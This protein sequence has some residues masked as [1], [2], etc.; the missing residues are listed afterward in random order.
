MSQHN[1]GRIGKVRMKATGFEFRVIP[2]ADDPESDIGASMI[3]HA[4][5]IA[6]WQG[7]AG[8]IV[9]GVFED[10][11]NSVG[12]RWDDARSPLPRSVMPTWIAEIVRREMITAPEAG[13][14]FN[15]NFQWAE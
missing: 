2:G 12:F 10:G 9:I 5:S 8:A 14:V 11:R 7:L 6:Q 13:E 15:E 4:R 1:A 3:R